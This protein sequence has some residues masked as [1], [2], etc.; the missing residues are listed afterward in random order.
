MFNQI[1]S[2]YKRSVQKSSTKKKKS[3]KSKVRIYV[4]KGKLY[5]Y[6]V[7]YLQNNRRSLLKN[8]L[9]NKW[10]TYS[11]VIKRLNVLAIYNKNRHPE[12]SNKIR[13]DIKYVETYLNKYSKKRSAKKRS[14][15]KR[16]T[17]KRSTKKRSTKK[18]STKKRST[19][20]MSTKKRSTKKKSAKKFI[21]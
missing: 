10:A 17:K 13:R 6:H 2:K 11:E 21:K 9:K 7:D 20:K 12:T 1:G 3:S 14:T 5:G 18:R 15:K 4:R 8:I 19:K 16:S